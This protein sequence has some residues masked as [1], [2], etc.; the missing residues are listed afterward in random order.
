MGRRTFRAAGTDSLLLLAQ[1]R[2]AGL[3][4]ANRRLKETPRR[5]N[6]AAGCCV[7]GAIWL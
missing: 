3:G 2:L 6:L 5:E 1:A 7:A 4:T